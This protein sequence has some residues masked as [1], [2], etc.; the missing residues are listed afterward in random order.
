MN[1]THRK[2][3]PYDIHWGDR[4]KV[5]IEEVRDFGVFFTYKGVVGFI[6]WIRLECK[7]DYKRF[8]EGETKQGDEYELNIGIVDLVENNTISLLSRPDRE[9]IERIKS[10]Y[11]YLKENFAIGEVLIVSDIGFAEMGFCTHTIVQESGIH[12]TESPII[13]YCTD[14]EDTFLRIGLVSQY[15][16]RH[17]DELTV[18]VIVSSFDDQL[19]VM[20]VQLDLMSFLKM[21]PYGT[22]K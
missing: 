16:T 2:D 3:L 20:Y 6:D 14:E 21:Y 8:T 4:V 18:P 12:R 19:L 7:E 1:Y 13:C 15:K 10:S 17:L 11:Y 22:E 5:R 9:E